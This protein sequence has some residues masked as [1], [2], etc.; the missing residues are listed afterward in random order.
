MNVSTYSQQAT[1]PWLFR[2][3]GRVWGAIVVIGWAAFVT[4]EMTLPMAEFPSVESFYQAAALAAVFAGYA[5][6][7]RMELAGG[8]L[9]ILGTAAFFVIQLITIDSVPDAGAACFALPGIFYLLAWKYDDPARHLAN[10]K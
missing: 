10:P 9:A 3:C 7:W 5:L 2:W 8:A 4:R 1:F 6:G